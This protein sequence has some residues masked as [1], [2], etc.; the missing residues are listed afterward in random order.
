MLDEQALVLQVDTF[1]SKFVQLD[2]LPG[3]LHHLTHSS[4]RANSSW[5]CSFQITEHQERP[6]LLGFLRTAAQSVLS[7]S[8]GATCIS[9]A[10]HLFTQAN[11]WMPTKCLMGSYSG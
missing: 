2:Q 8:T 11:W 3:L 5:A 6:A 7:S 9:F 1:L 4:S 10:S